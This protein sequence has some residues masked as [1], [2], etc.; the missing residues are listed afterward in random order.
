M[1]KTNSIARIIV[2]I[3]NSAIPCIVKDG[4]TYIPLIVGNIDIY[5]F[6]DVVIDSNYTLCHFL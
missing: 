3:I 2:D 4:V 5:K 1:T 6:V